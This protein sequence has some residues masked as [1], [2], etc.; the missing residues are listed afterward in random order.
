[1]T[2]VMLAV[3]EGEQLTSGSKLLRVDAVIIK[4]TLV[5]LA[6]S[7][8]EVAANACARFLLVG[9]IICKLCDKLMTFKSREVEKNYRNPPLFDAF[10]VDTSI[11]TS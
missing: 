6:Y 8:Q 5:L 3:E 9:R 1:M 11:H 10:L 2:V 4:R 7:R